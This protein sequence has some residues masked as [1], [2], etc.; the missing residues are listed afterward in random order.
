MSPRRRNS[1]DF[2]DPLPF[3]PVLVPYM[4][5][6]LKAVNISVLLLCAVG[7]PY[8]AIQLPGCPNPGH[9]HQSAVR[10]SL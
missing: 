10:F 2:D 8:E 6:E 7:L 4:C 3:T 9:E 5:L 1:N